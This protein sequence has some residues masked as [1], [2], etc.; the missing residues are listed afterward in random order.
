MVEH[1]S[2]TGKLSMTPEQRAVFAD[3]DSPAYLA[4][5]FHGIASMVLDE[6][7]ITNAFRTGEGVAWGEHSEC[8]FCGTEK[9]FRPGYLAM[10]TSKWIPALAHADHSGRP[11]W[12]VGCMG[13][14]IHQ[15]R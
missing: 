13:Q 7:K 12:R 14:R 1:D 2:A 11:P 6:P 10:L 9:F 15:Y 3:E 4:G 8:L 5:G